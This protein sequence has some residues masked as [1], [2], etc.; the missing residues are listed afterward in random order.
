[1]PT[2]I[3]RWQHSSRSWQR[4]R[5]CLS[6]SAQARWGRATYTESVQR[7]LITGGTG[8]LGAALARTCLREGIPVRLM[9]RDF[10]Q[11]GALLA[12]GAEPCKADLRDRDAV[13]AACAGCGLI[14]HAG[15]LSAPWGARRDFEEINFGGTENVLA[16]ARQYRVGRL[17]HISSPAVVFTGE[18][19]IGLTDNAPYPTRFLSDYARTK[20]EAEDAV[21]AAFRIGA[22]AGLILRPKAIFGP[23]DTSLLPRLV[24]AARA[25]RLP[26]IGDG[27]NRV[28]L[29]Y[30]DNVVEAIRRA[31]DAPESA[32]GQTFTI[33]GGEA[34][35][36]WEVI[37]RVLEALEIPWKPRRISLNG[38]L[39]AAGLMEGVARLTG[40]E[41]RLTRYTV[42][43]LARTQTY[44]TRAARELLSYVPPVSL[45][46]GIARTI[47][48]LK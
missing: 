9:G 19:A 26:I 4:R 5:L 8:F 33:D 17:I 46:E 21:N 31:M 40:R 6:L 7:A 20:K 28:A 2:S 22:V 16:G 11:V 15:A 27:E 44:D 36:L 42:S 1:M 14:V 12:A 35:K 45:D 38:A 25:G 13:V 34:P 30:I 47:E 37:G 18:D 39:A 10:S 23:G 29:T 48:A 24:T 3:Q 32:L 43:L 41:P